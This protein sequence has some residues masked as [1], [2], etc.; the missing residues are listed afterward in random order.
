MSG[1]LLDTQVG[2]SFQMSENQQMISDMIRK[3][4]KDHIQPKMME[5]DES[6]EFPVE[7]FKKLGELGLMGVLV[8]YPWQHTTVYVP[9]IFFSSVTKSRKRN[10]YQNFPLPNGL[11]PGA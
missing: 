10:I 3:F 9:D 8:P 4:G 2:M 1:Q 7:V 11:V 5:W 6:Q